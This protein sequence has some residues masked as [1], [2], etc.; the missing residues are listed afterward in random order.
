MPE[1][2]LTGLP[3]P[4]SPPATLRSF[5]SNDELVPCKGNGNEVSFIA[6]DAFMASVGQVPLGDGPLGMGHQPLPDFQGFHLTT[7]GD[8]YHIG[9]PVTSPM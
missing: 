8:P 1:P 2:N 7:S 5:R 3:L 6:V 4:S 9:G